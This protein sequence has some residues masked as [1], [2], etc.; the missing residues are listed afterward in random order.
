MKSDYY[1]VLPGA[2]SGGIQWELQRS[3][4]IIPDKTK[5]F[6]NQSQDPKT[7]SCGLTFWCSFEAT[8]LC[9][10]LCLCSVSSVPSASGAPKSPGCSRVQLEPRA[11]QEVHE[12][13][14]LLAHQIMPPRAATSE[15]STRR[16]VKLIAYKL[17]ECNQKTSP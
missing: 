3:A 16:N 6:P 11:A 5:T 15:V 2:G 8:R 1:F 10:G 9:Q 14:L 4:T 17:K 13:V 7:G 12:E